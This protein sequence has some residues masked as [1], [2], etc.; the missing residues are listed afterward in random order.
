MDDIVD[1]LKSSYRSDLF[2]N[3]F[4]R[5]ANEIVKLRDR[6]QHLESEVARLERLA[7]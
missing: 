6:I 3:L 4:D 5:A 1:Q 7:Q 2:Y